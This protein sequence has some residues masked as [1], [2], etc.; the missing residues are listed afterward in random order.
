ME[1]SRY[2]I[3]DA[4]TLEE[5]KHEYQ[6]SDVKGRIRLLRKLYKV[7]VPPYEVAFMAEDQQGCCQLGCQ[8]GYRN[9]C[10]RGGPTR[11]DTKKV[12]K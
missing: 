6:T 1:L 11:A 12:G 9:C 3:I 7:G 4:Y 10:Y 5:L 8:F 2:T